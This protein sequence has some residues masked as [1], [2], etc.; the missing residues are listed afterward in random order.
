MS[1]K[2]LITG[3]SAGIGA[4]Y[5][6]RLAKRGYDLV[7]VA[8]SEDKLRELAASL[9]TEVEVLPADLTD[10]ADL[11]RVA[12]RLAGVEVFVNNAG[13]SYA[14][15]LAD[16]DP[17]ELQKVIDLNVSAFTRLAQEYA[18]RRSGTLVNIASVVPI[19]HLQGMATYTASKAYTLTFTQVLASEQPDLRIQAVLPGA[20]GTGLWDKSGFPLANLDPEIVMSIDDVVDAA[21]AGLDAGELITIPSLPD[22]SHWDA[23]E[24]ARLHLVPNMSRREP[25]ERYRLSVSG[26]RP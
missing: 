22:A 23:Y 6:D 2:A 8:R 19:M 17:A 12:A 16:A 5:A 10:A 13:T 21:L 14:S 7:L 15:P 4:A 18:K 26:S 25:A 9:P 20:V 24:A 1:S 3:A 11:E